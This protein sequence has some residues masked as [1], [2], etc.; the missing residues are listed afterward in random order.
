MTP[1]VFV[2]S[3]A[4][5]AIATAGTVVRLDGVEGRHAATV[6]RLGVGEPLTLVD[7]EGTRATGTVDAV[8]DRSELD[9]RIVELGHEPPPQP[10]FVVVQALPK[11]DRGELA[12]E[13]LTEVGV[14]EIVPWSATNCVAQWRGDRLDRGRRRWLD[15]AQAAGKQARRARFPVIAEVAT[16]AAVVQRLRGAA[17]GLLL[18][19]EAGTPLAAVAAPNAGEI[20]I[21]VGPE[22][23]VTEA[24]RRAFAD[25]GVHEVRLGPTVLRTSTAGL[26][27]VSALMAPS[28]RWSFGL[29]SPTVEG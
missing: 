21:I 20:V 28:A 26:A 4:V 22:G 3:P 15:A 12:V 2:T 29:Q 16:T 10:R 24:E 25:A 19:E 14:D 23:G 11:G 27:A 7:G 18:H 17:L 1:P 5:L 9:V 6:R 13:L 8:V